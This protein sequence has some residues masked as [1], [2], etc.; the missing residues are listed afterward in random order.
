MKIEK[1]TENKI[2]VVINLDDLMKKDL[3][4]HSIM[5]KSI[6]TQG[7]ILDILLKAEKELGF[8]TEGCK[9]LIE[10]FSCGED[11][12]IFTITKYNQDN[13]EKE[14][15][16]YYPRPKVSV[17]AKIPAINSTHI[18]YAFDNFDVFC[19]FCTYINN[20]NV[21][22]KIAKNISLY[23]YNDIYYLN[24]SNITVSR[25]E[26][27]KFY[28]LISEFGNIVNY[29]NNFENKLIEYGKV[30]FKNNAIEKG[31]KYFA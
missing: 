14:S 28:S 23:L 24:I 15:K 4:S 16:N 18:I 12:F 5:S 1:L 20:K 30:I 21:K 11:S 8:N 17:K 26:A 2:R 29:S 7:L 22:K 3:D 19:N 31:I 27:E 9:L 25:K 13:I 6:E 10:A